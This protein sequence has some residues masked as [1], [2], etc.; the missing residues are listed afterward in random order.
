M[1]KFLSSI[2]V[3]FFL[4]INIYSFETPYFNGH[5][6]LIGDFTSNSNSDSFDPVFYSAGYLGGQINLFDSLIFRGEFSI[7][8]NDIL[9]N[10]IFKSPEGTSSIFKVQELSAT[11]KLNTSKLTHYFSLFYGEYEPIGSDI[12]LQRQFGIPKITSALTESWT[13]INGSSLNHFYGGGISYVMRFEQPVAFGTYIYKDYD[14]F[15]DQHSF[16][17]DIR[18]AGTFSMFTFDVDGGVGFSSDSTDGTFEEYVLIIREASFHAGFNILIGNP[19]DQL[20]LFIQSGFSNLIFAPGRKDHKED[21]IHALEELYFLVEPRVN[22]KQ[23]SFAITFFNVPYSKLA[24]SAYAYIY[25]PLGISTTISTDY[26]HLGDLN[27]TIG[28]HGTLTL[29][30]MTIRDAIKNK[31]LDGIWKRTFYLTPYANFPLFG[32]DL[33]SSLT[34]NCTQLFKFSH[35]WF[36]SM[37]Y[38]LGFRSQF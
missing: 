15:Y 26:F 23:M 3:T 6:G 16:N 22:L 11:Y 21:T 28:M 37:D 29:S 36:S 8:T 5:A 1:K 13:G 32:G 7:K 31:D 25:A 33:S 12:F 17:I 30:D 27:Y 20:S 35:N 18:A 19:T 38:R 34:I 14:E 24:S 9:G 4:I 10:D 2:I